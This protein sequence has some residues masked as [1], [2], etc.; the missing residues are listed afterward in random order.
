MT[1]SLALA[2]LPGMNPY[3][4]SSMT[5]LTPRPIAVR[6]ASGT[7]G[8]PQRDSQRNEEEHV[9]QHVHQAEGAADQT[10]DRRECREVGLAEWV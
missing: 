7:P 9:E 4:S 8:V 3:C 1:R 5:R 6:R 2:S 10:D